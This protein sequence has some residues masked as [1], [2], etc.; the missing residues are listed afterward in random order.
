MRRVLAVVAL[1]AVSVP[2]AAE[3]VAATSPPAVLVHRGQSVRDSANARLG[4]IDSVAS[5]GSIGLIVDAKYV[6]LPAGTFSVV[7]GK[8]VTQKTKRDL[9]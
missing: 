1:L 9:R 5:D 8:V 4:V 7:D 2:V 3:T 6:R